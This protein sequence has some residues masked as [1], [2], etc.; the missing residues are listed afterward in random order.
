MKQPGDIL[1]S[2]EMEQGLLGAFLNDNRTFDV[3]A[4]KLRPEHFYEQVHQVIF[5]E[6]ERKIGLGEPATPLTVRGALPNPCDIAGMTA[7]QYLAGLQA[8]GEIANHVPHLADT[9]GQLAAAREQFLITEDL[10]RSI[11]GGMPI[12]EAWRIFQDDAEAIRNGALGPRLR[13]TQRSIADGMEALNERMV[14]AINKKPGVRGIPTGLA[15]LDALIG[16]LQRGSLVVVAGRPAMG[17]S[18][19]MASVSR[20]IGEQRKYGVGIMSLEMSEEQI[21]SRMATE[22]AH[23]PRAW[24]SPCARI[25]YKSVLDGSIG[26]KHQEIVTSALRHL[27]ELPI[28]LDYATSMTVAQ[29]AGSARRMAAKLAKRGLTLDVLMIDYLKFIRATNRYAG[30]RYLEVGEVTGALKE[31][32]RQMN[33]CVVLFHQLNRE[34]EKVAD[35]RPGLEHLRESGDVEQDADVVI[36]LHREAYHIAASGDLDRPD[37]DSRKVEAETKMRQVEFDLDLIVA[38]QRMGATRDVR[39]FC[40]VATSS[41][42]SPRP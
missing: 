28:E 31:L 6:V 20:Q 35:K 29:V 30:Q 8:N 34:V 1:H 41:I 25:P 40:D 10:R 39:V 5:A 22:R 17:K 18:S 3:V 37:G 32:A 11:A 42:R 26:S 36:L 38:K 15:D 16:G 7:D 13:D 23:D 14:A 27:R 19:L 24:D 2:I 21:M 4:G 9:I 33:L 12:D